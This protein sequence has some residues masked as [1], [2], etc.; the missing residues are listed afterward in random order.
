MNNV[1]K[2]HIIYK[3]QIQKV[4]QNASALEK[5][6]DAKVLICEFLM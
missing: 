5:R 2:A 4:V 1:Q 3:R 6:I